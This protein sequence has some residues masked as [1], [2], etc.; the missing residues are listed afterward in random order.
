[1]DRSVRTSDSK[2]KIKRLIFLLYIILINRL[3]VFF[4]LQKAAL[5]LTYH[6]CNNFV[7]KGLVNKRVYSISIVFELPSS[8]MYMVATG[9][10]YS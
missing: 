8:S 1:M 2:G 5:T 4:Q 3:S 6:R 10:C 9:L 7:I